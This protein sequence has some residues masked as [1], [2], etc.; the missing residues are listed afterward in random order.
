MK[1]G[2]YGG[3]FKPLT[4]GHYSMLALAAKEND[5]VILL[6]G[7]AGRSKGS[8]FVYSPKM[9]EEIFQI[10]DAAIK[11]KFDNVIVEKA[12]PSPIYHSIGAILSVRDGKTEPGSLFDRLAIDPTK[13]NLTIYAGPDD[14]G[15]YQKYTG[16]PNVKFDTGPGEQ[17]GTRRMEAAVL[18]FDEKLDDVSNR[19]SIRGSKLRAM[20]GTTD[21]ENLMR[22]FPPIYTQDQKMRIFEIML[23]G[24]PKTTNETLRR[25]ISYMIRG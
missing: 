10:N 21:M 16:I 25:V 6:Y 13:I 4:M 5:T 15:T 17:D 11:E 18:H 3:G 2:I 14:I 7:M 22:Y 12:I 1:L 8:D 24:I 9:A 20:I 19:I 23:E